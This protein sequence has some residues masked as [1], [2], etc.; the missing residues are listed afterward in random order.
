MMS[1]VIYFLWS[2]Y[3]LRNSSLFFHRRILLFKWKL[4]NIWWKI[5]KIT[6]LKIWTLLLAGGKMLFK[7]FPERTSK[8]NFVFVEASVLILLLISEYLIWR[9]SYHT[10]TCW[11]S[12]FTTMIWLVPTIWSAKRKLM[13]KTDSFHGIVRLAGC[14]CNMQCKS[15]IHC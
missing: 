3:F 6:L 8:P 14:Q 13:W 9:F 12:V 2:S 15:V 1:T 4:G 10:T 7:I 5:K 11:L